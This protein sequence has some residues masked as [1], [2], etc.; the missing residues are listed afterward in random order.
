VTPGGPPAAVLYSDA[1]RARWRRPRFRGELPGANRVAEDV[2]P[3]C[4]DRVRFMLRVEDGIVRAARFLGDA[5]AIC[6]ASADLVAELVEGAPASSPR[7]TID[8]LLERL[9]AD[10]RPTRMQCVTL[11]L[12]VLHQALGTGPCGS[13]S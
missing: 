10:L 11:P 2:N 12:T 7:V 3:L 9:E 1:I 8:R 6:T 5:C 13:T 4:G